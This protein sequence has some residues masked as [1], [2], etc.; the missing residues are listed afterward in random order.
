MKN[1]FYF[2]EGR[3]LLFWGAKLSAEEG[4]ELLNTF[5]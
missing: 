5:R 3:G 2:S 1:I 4:E